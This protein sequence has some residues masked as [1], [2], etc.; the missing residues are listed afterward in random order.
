M[1]GQL[2]AAFKDI[3]QKV[4]K[5]LNYESPGP[6][7]ILFYSYIAPVSSISNKK[8]KTGLT[9]I[10]EAA[11]LILPEAFF[12]SKEE[13]HVGKKEVEYFEEKF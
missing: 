13:K 12:K 1:T 10:Q 6:F 7:E 2:K 3:E 11:G 9:K 4:L 5:D 8:I